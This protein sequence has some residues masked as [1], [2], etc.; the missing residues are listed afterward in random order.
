MD[1]V[2]GLAG[3]CEHEGMRILVTGHA[4]LL[5]ETNDVSIVCDPWFFGAYFGSWFP[6]PDNSGIDLDRLAHPDYLYISHLHHDHF[7]ARFLSEHVDRSATVLLP[8]FPLP[9]LRDELEAIGFSHFVPTRSGRWVDLEGVRIGIVTTTSV[10][11]GPIGDSALV[12][13]DGTSTI[14]DQNDCHPRD[15]EELLALGPYG[16]HFLQYSGAIWYPMVYRL[17]PETKAALAREKRVRQGE[18]ARRFIEEIDAAHVV[19]FAGPP[20]FLDDDLFA[21]N[22]LHDDPS[23][24]FQDQASFLR[25]LEGAGFSK[26]HLAVAGTEL[27]IVG[28]ELDIAHLSGAA[29]ELETIFCDKTTYLRAYQERRKGEIARSLPR[30]PAEAPSPDDLVARLAEWIEPLLER[31]PSVCAALR[32]PILLDLGHLGV[33]IDPDARRVRLAVPEDA[34]LASHTFFFDQSFLL[35]LLERHL[36]DWVNEFFLSCRFEAERHGE[37]NEVVFSFFKCLS[38]ERIDYLEASLGYAARSGA[39]EEGSTGELWR[40]GHYLVQRFCPHLGAD[41]SKFGHVDG[42]VLTCAMHG[43]RYDL[44]TGRCLTAEGFDLF[45]LDLDDGRVRTE[46]PQEPS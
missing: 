20:A 30:A 1:D 21:L 25:T 28:R 26:G 45:T 35:S 38:T 17:D 36:Q 31:A 9:D 8:D 32:G 43:N 10:A 46:S 40:C 3:R 14:L 33:L 29:L 13:D 34:A 12:V 22:D 15:L 37:Y 39:R 16:V 19:P 44:A 41:L 18:R 2:G 4:G 7:D 24:I 23:N 27:S 5:V 42:G 11:D 6:F